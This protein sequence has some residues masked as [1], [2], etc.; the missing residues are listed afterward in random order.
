MS[1]IVGTIVLPFFS[2]IG[3]F[4][5]WEIE[6]MEIGVGIESSIDGYGSGGGR[7]WVWST[8]WSLAN[9]FHW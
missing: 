7:D 3:R 8:S 6:K 2:I 4:D 1:K 5:S 9:L